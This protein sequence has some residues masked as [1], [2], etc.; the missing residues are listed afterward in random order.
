MNKTFSDAVYVSCAVQ[1]DHHGFIGLKLHKTS[2]GI[3]SL[4]AS[5]IFWD[6]TGQFVVQTFHSEIPLP[7]LEEL[8][9]EA[10]TTVK[11]Q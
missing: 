1:D 9:A 5:I 2:K 10:K 3:R 11:T 4:A 8:I 6:A 7:I